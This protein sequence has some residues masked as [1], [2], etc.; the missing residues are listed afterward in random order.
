[1]FYKRTEPKKTKARCT[2]CK[3]KI[4]ESQAWSYCIVGLYKFFYGLC[5]DCAKYM[6]EVNFK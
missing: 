5:E 1:M 4:D 6:A 3:K 2:A